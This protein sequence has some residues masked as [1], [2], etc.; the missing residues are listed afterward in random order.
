MD[1]MEKAIQALTEMQENCNKPGKIEYKKMSKQL[2]ALHHSE[3]VKAF[4]ELK[5]QDGQMQQAGAVKANLDLHPPSPS[6]SREEGRGDRRVEGGG[7]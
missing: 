1:E 6:S 4:H 7:G 5:K 3:T 2:A